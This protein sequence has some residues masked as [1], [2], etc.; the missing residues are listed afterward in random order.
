MSKESSLPSQRFV[1]VGEREVLV[2]ERFRRYPVT[3]RRVAEA[4]G[5]DPDSGHNVPPIRRRR[6]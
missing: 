4:L 5:L 2:D 3:D 1:T 6:R